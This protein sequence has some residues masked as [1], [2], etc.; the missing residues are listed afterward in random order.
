M[1][2]NDQESLMLSHHIE[3]TSVNDMILKDSESNPDQ[4]ISTLQKALRSQRL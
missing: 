1:R 2:V 3:Q 4:Y